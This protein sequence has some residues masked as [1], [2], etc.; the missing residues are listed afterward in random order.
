MKIILEKGDYVIL[1]F[2]GKGK[3]IKIHNYV[4]VSKAIVKVFTNNIFY[5]FGEVHDF[6]INQIE[7][8]HERHLNNWKNKNKS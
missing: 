7:I 4:W 1:P 6:S 5:T 3:I 8:D 2:N